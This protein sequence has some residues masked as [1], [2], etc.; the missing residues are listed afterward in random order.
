MEQAGPAEPRLLQLARCGGPPQR[1]QVQPLAL[2]PHDVNALSTSPQR[3]HRTQTADRTNWSGAAEEAAGGN[4]V[5]MHVPATCR[6]TLL[7]NGQRHDALND[8]L[9]ATAGPLPRLR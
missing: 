9:V 4:D 5:G 2:R 7:H 8:V 1:A 6:S 3:N